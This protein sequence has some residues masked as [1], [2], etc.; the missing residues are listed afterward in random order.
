MPGPIDEWRR[1]ANAI[2]DDVCRNGFDAAARNASSRLT[3]RSELDASLLLIP[4]VGFL[5]PDDPRVRGTVEAIEREL[6][7][8]RLRAALRHQPR[9]TACRPAKACSWPAASG[10]RTPITCI[11]RRHE[12]EQLFE[13][14]L[15]LRND[16]GLLSEEYD[17][18]EKRLVGNFPQAFS[19]MSL[20]NTAHNLCHEDKPAEQ[21][22]S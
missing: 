19:H 7:R 16:V 15:D 20:V 12:A 2:H 18:A 11:G 9:T 22:S 3:G 8:R 10:S 1:A 6:A 14:L 21:R 5:P 4:A 17:P 13:R